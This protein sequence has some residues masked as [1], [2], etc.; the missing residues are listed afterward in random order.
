MSL[1]GRRIRAWVTLAA[2]LGTLAIPV[3]TLGHFTP[4]DDAACGPVIGAPGH[5]STQVE[6]PRPA[7]V[8]QHCALCHWLRAVGGAAPSVPRVA[9]SLPTPARVQAPATEHRATDPT[10]NE[11][12]SRAPPSL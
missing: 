11:R 9:M 12:P 6:V 8:P 5:A 7:P 2:F 1:P 4:D 10:L 3:A